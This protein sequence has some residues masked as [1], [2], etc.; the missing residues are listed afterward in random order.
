MLLV[1]RTNL[2]SHCLVLHHLKQT[3][4]T[5]QP[6]P[7]LRQPHHHHQVAVVVVVVV[8]VVAAAAAAAVAAV[9][10]TTMSPHQLQLC[11]QGQHQL[12]LCRLIRRHQQL[13][14]QAVHEIRTAVL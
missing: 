14:R 4:V 3:L 1:R 5:L 10:M 8:V 6:Q 2:F 7:C 11:Q 9:A 12:R 13:C